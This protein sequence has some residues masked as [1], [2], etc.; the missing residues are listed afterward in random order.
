MRPL[1]T[2]AILAQG[3]T[4]GQCDSQGLF[5]TSRNRLRFDSEVGEN[6]ISYFLR[7]VAFQRANQI[8]VNFVKKGR[9]SD[10]SMDP[11]SEPDSRF[12]ED[13]QSLVGCQSS[14]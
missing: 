5:A 3:T 8:F 4:S 10:P 9:S 14:L 11:N 13:I 6:F 12:T 2:V 7:D 1:S